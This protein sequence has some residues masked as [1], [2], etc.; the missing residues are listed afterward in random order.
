MKTTVAPAVLNQKG[1]QQVSDVSTASS[2]TVPP[3]SEVVL[4]Q[5][6]TQNIRW[7]DDGVAPTAST[8]MLLV[9]GASPFPYMGK[10]LESLQ[11]IE[12]MP[13]AKLN[14]AFYSVVS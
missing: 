7:R 11:F 13:I 2:L 10:N 4:L 9:A 6:E 5:A 12:A 1:Y 3:G 14:V 8:G